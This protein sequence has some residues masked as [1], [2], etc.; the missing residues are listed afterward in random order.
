MKKIIS[1]FCFLW[2]MAT[3]SAM[4]FVYSAEETC[5]ARQ[6]SDVS[7]ISWVSEC[8]RYG[9]T[10]Q[11]DG[12]RNLSLIVSGDVMRS[13]GH[14]VEGSRSVMYTLIVDGMIVASS[15]NPPNLFSDWDDAHAMEGAV[16][17]GCFKE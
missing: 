9:A 3:V 12:P 17:K 11:L 7:S 15:E 16:R 5:A 4:D 1:G 2:A 8:L 14:Q 10:L 13:L 6:N